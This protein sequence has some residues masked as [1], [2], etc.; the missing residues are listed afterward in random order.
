MT[1]SSRIVQPTMATTAVT[2]KIELGLQSVR[3]Q[4][5]LEGRDEH[6]AEVE[7][8]GKTPTPLVR[9]GGEG[10]KTCSDESW[11]RPNTSTTIRRPNSLP[12]GPAMVILRLSVRTTS[13]EASGGVP[14]GAVAWAGPRTT[15]RS[16]R[17][18]AIGS[19]LKTCVDV[20][21]R[22]SDGGLSGNRCGQ[23]DEDGQ[24]GQHDH[25]DG[26]H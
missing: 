17:S 4:D 8:P 7:D 16:T 26:A 24:G 2:S 10:H 12:P 9:S 14:A 5:P 11:I 6:L 3:S 21:V 23:H 25:D 1:I 22:D 19:S 18:I 20:L 13:C 15:V